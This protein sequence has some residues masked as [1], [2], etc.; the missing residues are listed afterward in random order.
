M[1]VS[2]CSRFQDDDIHTNELLEKHDANTNDCSLP[3][4][5]P[6]A[7]EPRLNL[8]LEF[9]HASLCLQVWMPLD[10]DFVVEGDFSADLAP[11]LEDTGIIGREFAKLREDDKGFVVAAFASEPARR[12]GEE[13]DTG[14]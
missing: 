14:S 7:V 5:V 8:E 12:E 1:F 2:R 9:V 6:E 10:A 3:A 4:S 13:D 11:F